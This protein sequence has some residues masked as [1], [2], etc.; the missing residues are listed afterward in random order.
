[1][2]NLPSS[3]RVVEVGPRDGV[4]SFPRWIDT[5]TKVEMVDILSEAGFPVIEVTGFA[6]PRQIPN[7]RDA[8][9]VCER[10]TRRPGTIY[11]GLAPNARGAERAVSAKVDE[12]AGLITASTTYMKHNQNMDMEAAVEQGI[13]AFRIADRAGIGFLMAIGMAM[14][15]PYEG[16]IPEETVLGLIERFRDAGIRQVYLAGSLGMEHPA[17]VHEL[18]SRVT[19]RFPDVTF[20]YHAHNLAG[21]GSANIL[22]SIDAGA[23]FVEGAVCGLGGG[24][25]LPTTMVSVGN[26]PSEDIAAL[27]AGVGIETGL[28][29][30]AVVAAAR[31]IGAMLDIAP[32]S[33]IANAGTRSELMQRGQSSPYAHPA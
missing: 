8:E 25:A 4:Q 18:F 22:A 33:H 11:R 1:M 13:A 23:Q 5:E 10:I 2:W 29:L 24:V 26:L 7:L 20:G 28:D 27:L 21:F 30:D 17:Q 16:A 3:V 31:K 32:R 19:D 14:W 12:I 15:C 9:E 6:H